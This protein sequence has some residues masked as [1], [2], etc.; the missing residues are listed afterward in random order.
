MSKLGCVCLLAFLLATACSDEPPAASSSAA[1]EQ[2]FADPP[3]SSRPR[4]WW[5]WMNGN[6][7]K[8]GIA[9]VELGIVRGKRQYDKRETIARRE[10]DREMERAIHQAR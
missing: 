5:H 6:V 8:D 4:V 1:L 10:A 7:T 3:A 2:S 9:K